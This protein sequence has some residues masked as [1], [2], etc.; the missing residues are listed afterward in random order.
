MRSWNDA[1][2]SAVYRATGRSDDGVGVACNSRDVNGCPAERRTGHATRTSDC[3]AVSLRR[4]AGDRRPTRGSTAT[5]PGRSS[6][7]STP[8]RPIPS[9]RSR[10]S[11]GRAAEVSPAPPTAR[12]CLPM[13]GCGR[14]RATRGSSSACGPGGPSR[15]ASCSRSAAA[16]TR[17]GQSVHWPRSG[18]VPRAS[19]TTTPQSA[20]RAVF[21]RHGRARAAD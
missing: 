7:A 5:S 11:Y 9:R 6:S 1:T 20:A 16:S 13:R 15:P 4:S 12:S 17:N 18:T 2:P 19:R 21:L 14:R 8:P 3:H 10:S